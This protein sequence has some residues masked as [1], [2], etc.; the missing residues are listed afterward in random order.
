MRALLERLEEAGYPGR[1]G[2]IRSQL[3]KDYPREYK[4]YMDKAKAGF[5]AEKKFYAGK[6]KEFFE[7]ANRLHAEADSMYQKLKKKSGV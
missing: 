2:Q 6:G 1:G 3:E 7:L 5:D 4:A